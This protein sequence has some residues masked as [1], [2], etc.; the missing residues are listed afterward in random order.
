MVKFK[1]KSHFD[2]E[3]FQRNLEDFDSFM[4]FFSYGSY[5]IC[6]MESQRIFL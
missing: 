4:I 5:L 6:K 3:D 1:V 2:L